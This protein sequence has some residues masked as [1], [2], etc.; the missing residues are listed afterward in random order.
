VVNGRSPIAKT[1]AKQRLM[2]G[3]ERLWRPQIGLSRGRISLR[4]E[5]GANGVLAGGGLTGANAMGGKRCAGLGRLLV[6]IAF[7]CASAASAEEQKAAP[8]QATPSSTIIVLDGSRSMWARISGQ[9]KVA[10]VRTALGQAF[11]TY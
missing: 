1:P 5:G 2:E 7:L 9:S 8:A 3:S 4:C 11:A 10:L 6:P